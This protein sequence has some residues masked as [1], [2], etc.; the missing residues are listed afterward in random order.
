MEVE[1]ESKEEDPKTDEP[2]VS[3]PEV[4]TFLAKL[5]VELCD[6]LKVIFCERSFP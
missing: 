1:I 4:V 5:R 6:S 3:V 2:Q